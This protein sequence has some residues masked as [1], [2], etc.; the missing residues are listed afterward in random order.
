MELTFSSCQEA[1][2]FGSEYVSDEP[3]SY[4][5]VKTLA[6]GKY[7]VYLFEEDG[8]LINRDAPKVSYN[9]KVKVPGIMPIKHLG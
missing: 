9:G 3:G 6:N 4:Y 8:Y 1:E 7:A 5:E 2:T